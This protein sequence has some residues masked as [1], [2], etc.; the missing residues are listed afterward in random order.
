MYLVRADPHPTTISKTIEMAAVA[1]LTRPAEQ[2][3]DRGT[4]DP[5]ATH[6]GTLSKPLV[7]ARKG[8]ESDWVA[9]DLDQRFGLAATPIAKR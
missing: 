1:D 6:R 9:P 8:Y 4:A 5:G 2:R 7:R 3:A